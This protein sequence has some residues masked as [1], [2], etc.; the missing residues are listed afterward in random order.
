MQ[1]VIKIFFH[2][3]FRRAYVGIYIALSF[4]QLMDGACNTQATSST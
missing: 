1:L 2:A 3:E 4:T